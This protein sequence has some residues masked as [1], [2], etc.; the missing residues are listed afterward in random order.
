MRMLLITLTLLAVGCSTFQQA[1][2]PL[3]PSVAKFNDHLRWKRY[4]AAARLITSEEQATFYE[5]LA[6]VEETLDIQN[7]EVRHVSIQSTDP[8]KARVIVRSETT[9]L[10]STI[11]KTVTQT[12]IWEHRPGGWVLVGVEPTWLPKAKATT[13]K[14]ANV[15]SASLKD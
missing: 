13:A 8:V 4:D 14:V 5:A 3:Q 6:E 2:I 10:P 11:V 9:N 15:D 7:I 1:G 12:Q